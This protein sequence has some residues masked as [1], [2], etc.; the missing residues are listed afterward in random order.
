MIPGPKEVVLFCLMF[1][2]ESEWP[3]ASQTVWHTVRLVSG[4]KYTALMKATN[5][6][7][8]KAK[9]DCFKL[10]HLPATDDLCRIPLGMYF[11][12]RVSIT[13]Q[14]NYH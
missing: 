7:E 5:G 10:R 9:H 3:A 2:R 8:H 12:T 1:V 4:I 14:Q 11:L 13:W 6:E